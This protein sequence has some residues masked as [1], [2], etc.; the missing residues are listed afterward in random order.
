LGPF[1]LTISTA[2]FIAGMGPLYG[3]LMGQPASQYIHFL[4]VGFIFWQFISALIT[5]GCQ[6]F[7]SAEGFIKQ[8]RLPMTVYALRV[9]WRNVLIL[10]HNFIIVILVTAYFMPRWDWAVLTVPAGV[11]VIALNGVWIALLL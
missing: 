11:V 7:I 10:A 3:A 1:W 5:E 4:A 8:T 6:T 2:L 9:V